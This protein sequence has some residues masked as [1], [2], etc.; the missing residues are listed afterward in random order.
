MMAT[1]ELEK[2]TTSDIPIELECWMLKHGILPQEHRIAKPDIVWP[3][4]PDDR[5]ESKGWKPTHDGDE[6]P[7]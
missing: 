1:M 3:A 5:M 6:P 4:K 2:N 7:L